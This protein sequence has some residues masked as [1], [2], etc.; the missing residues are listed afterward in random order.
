MVA[1]AHK[2]NKK[3]MGTAEGL[4]SDSLERWRNWYRDKFFQS[5]NPLEKLQETGTF[6]VY[7]A[8]PRWLEFEELHLYVF[9]QEA[10]EKI[11]KLKIGTQYKKEL[12][13]WIVPDTLA[14]DFKECLE[15]SRMYSSLREN[16][17]KAVS[18]TSW[19]GYQRIKQLP[20]EKMQMLIDVFSENE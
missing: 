7:Y 9:K 13:G 2:L 16:A 11:S 4:T 15:F 6:W 14:Q 3:I 19:N 18:K 12:Q 5:I 1:S 8:K 20:P 10:I 17:I